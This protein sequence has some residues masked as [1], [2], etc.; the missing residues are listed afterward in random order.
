MYR[1]LIVDDEYHIREGSADPA[2]IPDRVRIHDVYS[3]GR[4]ASSG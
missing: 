4:F 3:S 2:V 1:L